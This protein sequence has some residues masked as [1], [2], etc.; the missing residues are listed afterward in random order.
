M[1]QF[2]AG[3]DGQFGS[4]VT[5]TSNLITMKSDLGFG[6]RDFLYYKMRSGNAVATLKNIDCETDLTSMIQSNARERE[7]RIVLSTD[8]V[9]EQTVVI[10]PIKNTTNTSADED[11]ED[12]ESID[13]YKDWFSYMHDREQAMGEFQM[14][15]IA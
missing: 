15:L 4:L 13:A 8:E 14:T 5:V 10:T 11:M 12:D 7:H 9:R 6:V 1:V 3:V 2:C